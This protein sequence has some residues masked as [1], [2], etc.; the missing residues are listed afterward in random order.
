MSAGLAIG[1]IGDDFT[2]SSDIANTLAR[3]GARTVLFAG[4]PRE[5]CDM[6]LDARMACCFGSTEGARMIAHPAIA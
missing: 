4:I 6:P 5:P 1:V 2:G 3:A